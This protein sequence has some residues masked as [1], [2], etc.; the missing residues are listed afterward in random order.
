M[1]VDQGI[2]IAQAGASDQSDQPTI[3]RAIDSLEAIPSPKAKLYGTLEPDPSKIKCIHDALKSIG[4]RELVIGTSR[5]NSAQ[6][7]LAI[8]RLQEAG[9]EIRTE[10]EAQ[11]CKELNFLSYFHQKPN[12]CCGQGGANLGWKVRCRLWVL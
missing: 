9:F 7:G 12:I 1:I 2:I 3:L 4:I 6:S 10:I 8:T 11:A 5:A